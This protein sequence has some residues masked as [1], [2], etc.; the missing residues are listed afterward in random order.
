MSFGFPVGGP[1]QGEMMEEVR[2]A[3]TRLTNMSHP[4]WGE[5]TRVIIAKI[6]SIGVG[7]D[8]KWA[9][10]ANDFQ[11]WPDFVQKFHNI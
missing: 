10:V 7:T 2:R 6:V 8:R 9:A 3:I 4:G 1:K 11:K 5:E